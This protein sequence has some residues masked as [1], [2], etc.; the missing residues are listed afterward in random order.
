MPTTLEAKGQCSFISD[1][2]FSL[3]FVRN[4]AIARSKDK[5]ARTQKRH[6]SKQRFDTLSKSLAGNS[7]RAASA[8]KDSPDISLAHARGL[9]ECSASQTFFIPSPIHVASCTPKSRSWLSA[10]SSGSDIESRPSRLLSLL[11]ST[12]RMFLKLVKINN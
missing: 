11:D 12:G 3:D 10:S 9:A 5:A 2:L 4:A 7:F 6:F 1:A 8:T